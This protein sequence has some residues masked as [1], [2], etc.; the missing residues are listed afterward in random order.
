MPKNPFNVLVQYSKRKLD[1]PF[2]VVAVIAPLDH[3]GPFAFYTINVSSHIS[4]GRRV[5]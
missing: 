3:A 4:T 2:T 5:W 1:N